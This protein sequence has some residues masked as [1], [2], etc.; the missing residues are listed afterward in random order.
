VSFARAYPSFIQA[1][2]GFRPG[3]IVSTKAMAEKGD[4][5]KT[6]PIGSGPFQWG[7]LEAGVS[8][9]LD[10]FNDYWGQKPKVDQIQFT[11]GVD[12]R[13]TVLAVAKGEVDGFY[14]DDPDVSADLVRRADPNTVFIKAAFG[15]APYWYAFNMKKPPLDNV[16]VRQALRYA[17]DVDAI[18]KDLFGGLADPIHSF[19]PPFMFG[20]S[21]KVTKFNYDPNK[22]KQMLK[23][24]NVDLNS[25]EPVMIASGAG[26]LGPNI[27][28]VVHSYWADVGVKAKNEILEGGVFLE[29]R[30]AGDYDMFGIGVGRIEPDQIATPYWYSTSPPTA[31]NSFYTLAD[32]LIDRAKAEPDP[33][34]RLALYHDLQ[35]KMSQD[36]PAAFI[37]ATAAHLLVNKRVAGLSGAGWQ[38]RYDWFNVDVP[39]E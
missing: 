20:Y 23:E 11:F 19:L 24:A 27:G 21:N 17:I 30:R 37:V 7:R 32:D 28:E 8:L 29:R 12:E 16:V 3:L 13:A 22:A 39:A 38:N 9:T 34:K 33:T 14:I 6:N 2:L 5:W 31:N 15:T 35:E 1:S 10:R 4:T 18:A 36:S 26:P 25:W